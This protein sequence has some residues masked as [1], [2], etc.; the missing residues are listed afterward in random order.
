MASVTTNFGFDV[1]TSSDLVKNG[2]TQIALLGQ[3]I[4]TFLA[5]GVGFA[6]GKNAVIN[7]DMAI[8]QRNFSSS[9]ADNSFI[10]DRWQGALSGAS[11]TFSAQTFTLGTA[12]VAGY[13]AKNFARMAVTTG[14]DYCRI[15]QKIESVRTLA[16]RTVTVSFWAKGT[17]PTTAGNVKFNYTQNY[18]T[19]GSPS[20]SSL[21]SDYTFVLTANWTRYSF[22]IALPSLAGKTL[23]TNGDDH[24]GLFFG[25]GS[26]TSADTYTLDL[27]GVQL[28]TG[29]TP[30]PFQT[31]SGGSPQAELAM[32]QRY[33]YRL[34][35]ATLAW[36]ANYSTTVCRAAVYF[37]VE[38]RITPTALEQSGTAGDYQVSQ[39]GGGNV[40]LS[41]VPLFSGTSTRFATINGVVT[42]GLTIFNP[43]YIG[44]VA[45][46]AYLGWSAEL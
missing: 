7:A 22:T 28:E 33:Y 25:Q 40:T 8:N 35:N 6:G 44:Q 26:S 17:N 37:P 20:A 46:T 36:G 5:G 21:S 23:G 10:F 41:G 16:G 31:A 42:A 39:A 4:D 11:A 14:N 18:G 27:W 43:A 19:G 32:C 45:S 38:M 3:D 30:T 1:P 9:T 13:E 29:S 15:Q 2:A 34:T 12:P 24:L